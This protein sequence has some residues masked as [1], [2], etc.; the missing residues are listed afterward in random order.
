MT[1][2]NFKYIFH[3]FPHIFCVDPAERKAEREKIQE[4]KEIKESYD[5][6]S[7]V[8]YESHLYSVQGFLECKTKDRKKLISDNRQEWAWIR[9]DMS[10]FFINK[11]KPRIARNH[12]VKLLSQFCASND[13][14]TPNA[15][16]LVLDYDSYENKDQFIADVSPE[17]ATED[18]NRNYWRIVDLYQILRCMRICIENKVPIDS[19]NKIDFSFVPD[20][21]DLYFM[22]KDV[23]FTDKLW[24]NLVTELEVSPVWFMTI[25]KANFIHQAFRSQEENTYCY[26]TPM[27]FIKLFYLLREFNNKI[28]A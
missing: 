20:F 8:I 14:M 9:Y 21:E 25:L 3:S 18:S 24:N 26:P 15:F 28:D 2:E 1:P 19:N 12:V 11:I 10:Q 7:V 4:R 17:L 16:K 5:L 6:W 13:L 22:E 23:E 27:M